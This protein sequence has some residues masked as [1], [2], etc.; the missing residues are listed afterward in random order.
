MR[1]LV[2]ES[3]WEPTATI[4]YLVRKDVPGKSPSL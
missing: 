3:H 4:A 2:L 1:G